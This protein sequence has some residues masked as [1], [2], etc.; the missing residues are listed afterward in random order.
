MTLSVV[1]RYG[2]HMALVDERETLE[3]CRTVAA[4]LDDAIPVPG[5]DRRVGLDSILGLLPVA[6]DAVAAAAASYIVLEAARLGAPRGTLVRMG[7]NVALDFGVGSI[8]LL[9][10]LFDAAFK[11]NLKNV[12]LLERHLDDAT[13]EAASESLFDEALDGDQEEIAA[14]DAS[15]ATD[16]DQDGESETSIEI[17][18]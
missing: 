5:T 3:R 10:D 12:E 9:G 13:V 2:A 18:D 7:F 16:S 4:A 11:A 17:E 1:D 8:P 6:G 14:S 15:E